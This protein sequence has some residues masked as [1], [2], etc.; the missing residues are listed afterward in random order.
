MGKFIG[1]G[2][3]KNHRPIVVLHA[4]WKGHLALVRP[5]KGFRNWV[6]PGGR[7]RTAE[8]VEE[9]ACRKARDELGLCID[10][11]RLSLTRVAE[12]ELE[13]VIQLITVYRVVLTESERDVLPEFTSEGY[14][15]KLQPRGELRR[16][17]NTADLALA[18]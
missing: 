15:I 5:P 3:A 4:A 11:N 12:R 1:V 9:A 8:T 17:L 16:F 13:T 18:A 14:E 7:V 6:F 10:P 2:V